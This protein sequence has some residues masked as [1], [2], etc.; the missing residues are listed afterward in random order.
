MQQQ[1][2]AL[3]ES[4]V[5]SRTHQLEQANL[6]LKRLSNTDSLTGLSNRRGFEEQVAAAIEQGRTTGVPVAFLMLDVDHFKH[7]NDTFGHGIGDECLAA[8]GQTLSEYSRRETE[9]AA[10]I[11]GEEFATVFYSMPAV[12]AVAVA[13]Q[14]RSAIAQLEIRQPDGNLS[15]TISIGVAAWIPTEQDSNLTY[16]NAADEALYRA[17]AGGRNQVCLR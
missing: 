1:N 3:L 10:R 13:E 9:C 12:N 5:A 14:I 17:K 8:V 2:T 6:E 11:G 15:F 7:I 4:S 16:A